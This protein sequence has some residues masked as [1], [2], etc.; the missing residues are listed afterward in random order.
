[1]RVR[2]HLR[3][4]ALGLLV[5]FG[6]GS[7]MARLWTMQ[8]DRQ[9]YYTE[10]L[11]TTSTVSVRV[12]ATRGRI[13]DR[14]GTVLVDNQASFKIV[15]DL[16]EVVRAYRQEMGE[17]PT[18][19][20]EVGA[21][22][23]QF[24]EADIVSIFK[25]TVQPKLAAL[26]LARDFNAAS[27]RNHYRTYR[28]VV[29][30]EYPGDATFRE[31]V[32]LAE[33]I[34]VIPGTSIVVKPRRIYEYG[35]LASHLLGYLSQPDIGKID[36]ERLSQFTYFIGDDYGAAGLEKT[37]NSVLSG[38]P[39]KR[40]MLKNE[41]GSLVGEIENL[42]PEAGADVFLTLDA[43]IQWLTEQALR[44]GKVGRGA[45]VVLDPKTG[46][47][48]AMASVPSYDANRFIP[49]I[50]AEVW[51]AYL[52][53]P[54]R[55]L[56]CTALRAF[57]PGSTFKVV[58]SLGAGLVGMDQHSYVCTG[59]V[60]YGDHFKKCWIH[61]KGG[62]HGRL[63][64]EEAIKVSCNSYYYLLGNNLRDEPIVRVSRM[65]GLGQESGLE[66][67]GLGEMPGIVPGSLPWKELQGRSLDRPLTPA[68]TANLT[69]GQGETL[70]TP[71]QMAN[72]AASVANGGTSYRPSLVRFAIDKR[73]RLVHQAKEASR[74]INLL[75]EGVSARA[76]DAVRNGM[77]KAANE[78]GGTAQRGGPE[79]WEIGG[80]TGTAQTSIQ[81]R[82]GNNSWFISFA[83]F[84]SPRYAVAVVVLGGQSGGKVAAPVARRIYEGL[85]E[86]E[87]GH[88]PQLTKL[89]EAKG[90]FDEAE[91]T[92]YGEELLVV[93]E[94]EG[95][96]GDEAG[97]P[98]RVHR[99][100][101]VPFEA[102]DDL[103]APTPALGADAEGSTF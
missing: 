67:A 3:L 52:R 47:I 69:I 18:V 85:Q 83:P 17:M 34:G 56:L 102:V 71:L 81:G 8:V 19:Q 49:R 5:L 94:A 63:G 93:D 98:L 57:E 74:A 43:R 92:T 21:L 101:A 29:P 51:Q 24:Q 76:L 36:R 58:V 2:I 88:F 68:E 27:L 6:F 77:W 38:K 64:L 40:V 33:R 55:P 9:D 62:A 35:A 22:P 1:M 37:F 42:A 72:V 7:L 12:P 103:E 89:E 53:D 80:K 79:G 87:K 65:L 28:G 23:K 60:R 54:T 41:K 48:L 4:A 66:L 59:G 100:A 30:F 44:E 13:L 31:S 75:E 99:A 91:E 97:V 39:G 78:P 10:I 45:A 61:S 90:F 15:V 14:N 95:E 73:G 50:K 86:M 96:S 16:A 46:E 26:G 82:R 32:R 11:P 25:E 84:E 20:F 70:A